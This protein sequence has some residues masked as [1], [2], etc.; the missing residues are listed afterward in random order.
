VAREDDTRVI[1]LAGRL[2]A[3]Q[4]P[5]F[6]RACGDEGAMTLD[7]TDL[8]SVDPAGIDALQRLRRQGAR[9]TGVTGYI[10]LRLDSLADRAAA[11][12]AGTT[13]DRR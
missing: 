7:L 6:F 1:R 2:S 8:I 5:D 13:R 9:L 10:Q 3:E 12:A 11:S 4:V